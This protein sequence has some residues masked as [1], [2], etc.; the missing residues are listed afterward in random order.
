MMP[1]TIVLTLEDR[2]KVLRSHENGT[3]GQK[4]T[5]LFKLNS[6]KHNIE[7]QR[8]FLKEYKE[9]KSYVIKRK[10]RKNNFLSLTKLFC[11]GLAVQG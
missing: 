5:A 4:L 3:S 10:K 9:F 8:F 7:K 6:N 11:S 1:K 2:M